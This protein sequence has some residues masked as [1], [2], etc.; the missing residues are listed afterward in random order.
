MKDSAVT[1][2]SMTELESFH[3]FVAEN[4]ANGG[5]LSPEEALSIWRDREATIAAVEEGLRAVD[6]GRTKSL[7]EFKRDFHVKHQITDAP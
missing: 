7:D 4:I 2:D 3:Q 6:E 5:N 1:A